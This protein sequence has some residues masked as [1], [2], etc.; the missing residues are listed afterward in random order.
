MK[1]EYPIARLCAVLCV[2]R[3]GYY[4]WRQA[5]RSVR[6][7]ADC[8]LASRIC[9]VH[10]AHRGRY[11]APRIHRELREQGHRHGSKR[12]ARLM[13]EQGLK[14]LCPKLWVPRTTN[15]RH[16]HGSVA[17]PLG[18]APCACGTQPSVGQRPGLCS[19][20]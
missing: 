1:S 3:A 18:G 20:A 8:Q 6:A 5:G 13:R 14:T 19:H 2:C 10:R 15:S 17:Q 4:A 7:E 9:E 11:G 16:G 12:I